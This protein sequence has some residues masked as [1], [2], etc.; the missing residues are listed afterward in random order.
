MMVRFIKFQLTYA[1]LAYY[2]L[3]EPMS[4]ERVPGLLDNSPHLKKLFDRIEAIP[5]IK[6]HI[7]TRPKT[8]V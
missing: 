7:E 8:V 2:T 5:Q 4:R 3:F 1:D 6:A